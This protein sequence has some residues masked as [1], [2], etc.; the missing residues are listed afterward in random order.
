MSS[1]L[2]NAPMHSAIEPNAVGGLTEFFPVLRNGEAALI[3]FINAVPRPGDIL[4]LRAAKLE[5]KDVN[6]VEKSRLDAVA[7]Q[8]SRA[9]TAK[10]FAE[11]ESML[12]QVRE[13]NATAIPALQ[14]E[15][16]RLSLELEKL[17]GRINSMK[18]TESE[19][20]AVH[21]PR[22][23][24]RRR[25]TSDSCLPE[26]IRR[27]LDLHRVAADKSLLDRIA[28][29]KVTIPELQSDVSL[30]TAN[31]GSAVFLPRVERI[32][33]TPSHRGYDFWKSRQY[34]RE[35]WAL[36]QNWCLDRA[37]VLKVELDSIQHQV[38]ALDGDYIREL[39]GFYVSTIV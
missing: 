16:R 23:D 12:V 35:E 39:R 30:D 7:A 21:Q 1:S 32:K 9:G 3:R 38:D 2:M 18:E 26:I 20:H 28:I 24:A 14:E 22:V 25:L 37:E 8:L 13:H 33:A 31:G 10:E 15:R 27:E 6:D 4:L 34:S 29:L 5:P 36:Y 19:R 17:D 11:S